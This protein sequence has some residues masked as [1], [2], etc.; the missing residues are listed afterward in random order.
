MKIEITPDE[1]IAMIKYFKNPYTS[2]VD[3]TKKEVLTPAP[4]HG[5]WTM[6]FNI[7]T[8]ASDTTSLKG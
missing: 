7:S 2:N 6:P 1:L 3:N 8:T 5:T 4:V